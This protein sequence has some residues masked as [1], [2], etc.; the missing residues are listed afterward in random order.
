MNTKVNTKTRAFI[1]VCAA[2]VLI[3]A[4]ITFL[5]ASGQ[6]DRIFGIPT[7]GTLTMR[8]TTTETEIRRDYVDAEGK[9][10]FAADKGYATEK[11]TLN[12]KGKNVL[13][14][15]Y[16]E[17]GE[18]A[19]LARG[20]HAIA[21]EY[22]EKGQNDRITYLDTELQ[23]VNIDD[24]YATVLRTYNAQGKAETDTYQDA[25][26]RTVPKTAGYYGYRREYD[27]EGRLSRISYL[28]PGGKPANQSKGYA[29]ETRTYDE[30]GKLLQRR[31][32]DE[33][34]QP[35][36]IGR[37]QY[38]VQYDDGKAVYLDEEGNTVRRLDNYLFSHP[39]TVILAA[40]ALILLGT[41]LPEKGRI[42]LLVLYIGFIVYMT[43]VYREA[44]GRSTH[45]IPFSSY[46]R[47]FANR[48]TRQE[49]LNNIWLFVPL[50]FLL[51]KTAKGK[52]IWLAPAALSV[53]IEAVQY[54]FGIGCCEIDDVISNGLGGIIG[55]GLGS[56]RIM[57]NEQL[58]MNN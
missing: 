21:R 31:F 20:Y 23:P 2:L 28:N 47:F 6:F 37:M 40:A 43:I 35:A 46:R 32:F 30:D 27:E 5:S 15:Y 25:E 42:A 52:W 44:G 10:R 11:R 55:I 54:V 22:N 26:G 13:Q 14:A 49:I 8:K 58:R 34:G 12:E 36:T 33:D 9:I 53:L 19:V 45:L 41:M 57:K 48:S 18:P 3:L 38:G 4:G 17:N 50:G 24:G 51:R 56:V 1:G 29:V 39:V 7:A 16:D